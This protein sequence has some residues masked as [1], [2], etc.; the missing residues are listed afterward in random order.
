MSR[1]L[2]VD[3]EPS[4]LGALSR[5]LERA[6]HSVVSARNAGEALHFVKNQEIDLIVSDFQL[7]GIDGIE[8]IKILRRDRDSTPVIMLTGFGSIDHAM[9]AVRAGAEDYLTKPFDPDHLVYRIEQTLKRAKLERELDDLRRE[10]VQQRSARTLL[11]KSSALERAMD[12]VI[13]A[14]RSRATVLLEG[15]S[16]TGKELLAREIHNLSDRRARP[17][18]KL[19]CAA[20]PEGLVESALFGH[21]KGAFT[22]AI[23]RVDGAFER[24]DGGTLLL[25]EISEMRVDLQAKLLRVLQEREFERVGGS[26]SISVDVRVIATTNRDLTVEIQRGTFRRDL[27]YRLNVIAITAPPLRERLS[28]VPLLAHHFAAR[29]AAESGKKI[30]GITAEAIDLLQSYLWP[31]NVRELQH[32]VERAVVLAD[33][34]TLGASAFDSVR[35]ALD[36]KRDAAAARM[37]Q[38]AP[39]Q[40]SDEAITLP[41]L[42]LGK[43]E[44]ALIA[45]ALR[46]SNNNRTHAAGLLGI[47]VRTLRKKLNS[48]S[49]EQPVA[50]D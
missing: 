3:D 34:P 8:F 12:L 13:A 7:P 38:F 22:G 44:D 27:F 43:A 33:Q 40:T 29:A 32:A 24:A 17:F 41:T 42:D 45:E 23:R 50:D 26:E 20:L 35:R 31:G 15:E 5:I 1:I 2:C 39:M 47:G 30:E 18:I 25:D 11:G 9:D 16:G 10:V 14:A 19:N 48:P 36:V 6:G 49:R 28:D 21:E 46:V 37:V 4:V